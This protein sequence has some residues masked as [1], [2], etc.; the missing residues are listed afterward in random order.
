MPGAGLTSIPSTTNE[1]TVRSSV[2]YDSALSASKQTN[3]QYPLRRVSNALSGSSEVPLE[4]K[5]PTQSN[6]RKLDKIHIPRTRWERLRSITLAGPTTLKLENAEFSLASREK[7][8]NFSEMLASIKGQIE[9][10]GKELPLLR[11][12]LVQVR[13]GQTALDTYIC[14]QGL[15]NAADITRIHAAMPRKRYKQLYNP[16]KLF[17]ETSDLVHITFPDNES[18]S[19]LQDTGSK[20]NVSNPPNARNAM[21]KPRATSA[22]IPPVEPETQ[23]SSVYQYLPKLG[24]RTYCGAL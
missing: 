13:E 6:G 17:Y 9:L 4:A 21:P 20:S 15:K 3:E 23:V 12:S 10:F 14:I 7:L 24:G 18:T 8:R 16:L 22:N 11:V 5:G 2:V 19:P 1:D